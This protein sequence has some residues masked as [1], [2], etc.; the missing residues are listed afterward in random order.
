MA[1]DLTVL[2]AGKSNIY[3]HSHTFL[4]PDLCSVANPKQQNIPDFGNLKNKPL[5]TALKDN[6]WSLFEYITE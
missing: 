4:D 1:V 3:L 5:Y 6:S 2:F